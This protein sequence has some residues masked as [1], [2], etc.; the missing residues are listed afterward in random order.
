LAFGL[1]AARVL[2]RLD[3]PAHVPL[4]DAFIGA[5]AAASGMV[6][7]PRNTEHFAPLGVHVLNPWL[8]T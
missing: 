6:V 5:V 1:D 7:V 4:D 3:V 8:E 2:A